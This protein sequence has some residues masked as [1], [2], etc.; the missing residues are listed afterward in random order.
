M[1]I[2]AITTGA[3][4]YLVLGALSLAFLRARARR[5]LR[6]FQLALF[7]GMAARLALAAAAISAVAK[8]WRSGL[9]GFVAGLLC[10][11]IVLMVLEIA[12]VYRGVIF[13]NARD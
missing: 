7:G 9:T 1:S 8:A 10:A 12:L 2:G 4:F 6:S 13:E 11:A 5:S 3:V